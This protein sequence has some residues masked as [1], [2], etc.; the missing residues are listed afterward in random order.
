[1]S[2]A[3]EKEFLKKTKDGRFHRKESEF[4]DT[5]SADGSSG[6]AAEPGRYHLYIAWACP[7]AHRTLLARKL[8]GLEEAITFSVVHPIMDPRGAWDFRDDGEHQDD[9]YGARSLQDIY[10]KADPDFPGIGTV[11]VLWDKKQETIVNNESRE[12]VRMLA[13]AFKRHKKSKRELYHEELHGIIEES[14]DA[15]YEPINNGVYRS[16]FAQTQEAYDE[17]VDQLFAA[18]DHWDTVL[19]TQ[20]YVCG[21]VITEPDLFLFSTL[22]RFDPVYHYHFKCNIRRIRDYP[23]LWN[24]TKEIYQIP[25]VKETVNMAETKQHYFGSHE[26]LNPS[27]IVPKGP[28]IDLDSPHDRDLVAPLPEEQPIERS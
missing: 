8:L 5:I 7:W 26:R 1:M 27:R 18:L 17:A 10:K 2:M 19:D 11:P 25:G 28:D 13:T 22:L 3:P 12:I 16:G 14:I 21:H 15:I 9:L 4:R 23:N 6:F 24:H 20:R